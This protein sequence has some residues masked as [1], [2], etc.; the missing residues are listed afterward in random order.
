MKDCKCKS[1]IIYADHSATTA[2]RPEV[3]D[4]MLSVLDDNFG[5]PSSIH[6]FGRKAKNYLQSAREEIASVINAKPEE[7]FFTSGGTES[8]NT[9]VSGISRFVEENK[10]KEKHIIST[11]IEHPAVKEPLEYLEKKGWHISLLSPNQEGFINIEELKATITP[12]TALVSII[13]ANN[14]IGTIQDIKKI[15]D[16]CKEHNVL[17]HTDAVQSFCKIPIDVN[18]LNIDFMSMSGHKIYGPKGIGALYIRS[19]AKLFPLI[20]GG[21]QETGFRSGTENMPGVAG[22]SIAC[23]LLKNEMPENA[24]KLRHF[25]IKLMEGLLK[26]ENIML[27][28]VHLGKVKENIPVEKF[29]HRIPGHV[30]LCCKNIE[31]ESLV[32]QLDLKG[33]ASSSGSACKNKFEPSHVLKAIGI[34]KD[35]VMGSV[36]F[37]LG[38]ENIEKEIDY[39]AGTVKDIV[40]KIYKE[41][42]KTSY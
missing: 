4:A 33:I 31:G 25:Q 42:S 11:Q 13:H 7:L 38:R 29:L 1:K 21:G 17:F 36:R 6:S 27:T 12:K 30:S 20:I 28:G 8:D 2:A 35:Y 18:K 32:L 9:V 39:I 16:L 19:Q 5:N 23:K 24:Q 41:P 15:G 37:T 14:E 10:N 22:F 40:Q 3:I 34:P 26:V